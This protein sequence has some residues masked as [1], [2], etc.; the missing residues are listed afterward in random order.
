MIRSDFHMHT[1]FCDGQASPEE[2]VRAAIEKGMRRVGLVAHSNLAH[3]W[4]SDVMRRERLPSFRA[5]VAR[6]KEQ[7]RDR[8][9]IFCGLELDH[10]EPVEPSDY[11]YLIGSVHWMEKDGRFISALHQHVWDEQLETVYHGDALA[12]TEDYFAA[13]RGLAEK[14]IDVVGHFDICNRCNVDEKYFSERDPRYLRAATDA[15]DALLALDIPFEVNMGVM[16]RGY[17]SKPNPDEE[18]LRYIASRG[19]RVILSSDAHCPATVG[20][21]FDEWEARIRATVPVWDDW[22]PHHTNRRNYHDS[23]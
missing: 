20:Y 9:E 11:D 2:M 5:E 16:G 3:L 7:Y 4:G 6:L 1:T 23:L 19:G 22:Q 12:F 13:V 14:P 8:I 21:G 18:I 10:D 17:R 15:A